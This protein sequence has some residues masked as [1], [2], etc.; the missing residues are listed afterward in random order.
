M[1]QAIHGHNG[2]RYHQSLCN[3]GEDNTCRY[4]LQEVE[5][6]FHLYT[7]CPALAITRFAA[8]G[9]YHLPVPFGPA[10]WTLDQLLTFAL[11]PFITAALVGRE[12]PPPTDTPP[13]E[14]D[15][16]VDTSTYTDTSEDSDS[17]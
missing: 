15:E 9:Q 5:T 13:P 6:F 4:C 2:L 3:H 17:E 16:R 7:N 1:L 14:T 8:T 10:D 11:H 12:I